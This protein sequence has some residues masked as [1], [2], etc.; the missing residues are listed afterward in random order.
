MQ[1]KEKQFNR[2]R[3]VTNKVKEVSSVPRLHVFRSNNHMYAQVI[4]TDGKIVAA[5]S[6]V[7]LKDGTKTEKAKVVGENVAKIALKNKVKAVAFDRGS[8]KF[9][10]RVKAV[11]EAARE[12]GLAF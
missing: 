10:G 1:V 8:Y 11:A 7:K 12:A 9:H 4:G 3:R 5:F 2:K 6:D